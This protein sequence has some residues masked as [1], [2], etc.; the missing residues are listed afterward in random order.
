[1]FSEKTTEMNLIVE[2]QPATVI[3]FTGVVSS[4]K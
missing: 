3:C 4:A 1:M 2:N